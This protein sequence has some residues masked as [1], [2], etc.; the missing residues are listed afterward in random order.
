[1]PRLNYVCQKSHNKNQGIYIL[2][3]NTWTDLITSTFI[4][5]AALKKPGMI[6]TRTNLSL[7]CLS[8]SSIRL[9]LVDDLIFAWCW[10]CKGSWS[11]EP[12]LK[13]WLFRLGSCFDWGQQQVEN[14]CT[15]ALNSWGQQ[16]LTG[17]VLAGDLEVIKLYSVL[18]E[19]AR[20]CQAMCLRK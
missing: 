5:S 9:A 19:K 13:I 6:C 15:A 17:S 20:L 4:T 2:I 7:S 3:G 18:S 8:C 11:A 10:N 16:R 12:S 14:C 1:M